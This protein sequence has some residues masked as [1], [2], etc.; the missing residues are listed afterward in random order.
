MK[1]EYAKQV[2]QWAE[3]AKEYLTIRKEI[4][5][6]ENTTDT[7]LGNIIRQMYKAKVQTQNETILKTKES[8]KL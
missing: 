8:I 4:I 3:E 7:E 5:I 1:K 2:I 6:D